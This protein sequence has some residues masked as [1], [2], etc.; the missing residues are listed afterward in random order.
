MAF[1]GGARAATDLSV[2]DLAEVLPDG[3]PSAIRQV[4][5]DDL[6]AAALNTLPPD[7]RA[8]VELTYYEGL[9]YRDIAEILGCPENTVKTRMFH[10]RKKL[11]PF[12]Q[13][14][15]PVPEPRDYPCE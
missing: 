9:S 3:K 13:D 10:A 12:F 5:L 15:I 2:D 6:L 4:E 11:L 8:V 1:S 7:Q 14:V